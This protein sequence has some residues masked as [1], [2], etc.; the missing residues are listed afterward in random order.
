MIDAAI[1]HIAVELNQHL[2]R[3]F[4]LNEDLVVISNILEQDGSMATLVNDKIVIS[5]VNIERDVLPYQKQ[6][7]VNVGARRTVTNAKPV[8][9][10]L[11]LIFA[12][13]FSGNNYREGL[14]FISNTI[15]FFQSQPTFDRQTS[16]GLD[17]RID[18]LILDIENLSI[19]ELSNLWGILS[20][21]YLP[22]ILYKV[23]MVTYDSRAVR[24]QVPVLSQP[25]PSVNQ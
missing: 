24:S 4:D 17:K 15:G 12:S 5:L 7:M 20:G 16:P 11:Y 22:S 21:K 23:R 8:F 6:D 10:N 3:K 9:F 18:R 14:K 1:Q 13:C 2:K 19:H 25:Q